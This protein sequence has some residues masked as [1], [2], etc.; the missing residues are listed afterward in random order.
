MINEEGNEVN[1]AMGITG[2]WLDKIRKERLITLNCAIE[3]VDRTFGLIRQYLT[4]PIQTR[5]A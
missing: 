3:V 1:F 4:L 5:L 2:D